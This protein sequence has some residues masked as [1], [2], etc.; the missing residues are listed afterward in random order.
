VS[1]R[2]AEDLAGARSVVEREAL[3]WN[4]NESEDKAVA[5][6]E[7]ACVSLFILLF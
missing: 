4:L 3:D 1:W 2:R 5:E 7:V 6:I